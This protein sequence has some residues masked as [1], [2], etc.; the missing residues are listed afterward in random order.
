MR[1]RR[2]EEEVKE[3]IGDACD[4]GDDEDSDFI[5]L[6]PDLRRTTREEEKKEVGE[7]RGGE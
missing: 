5:Y 3:D 2:E 1:M 7:E 6:R 4:E